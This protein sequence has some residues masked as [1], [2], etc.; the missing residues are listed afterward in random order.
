MKIPENRIN[1]IL[2]YE[3]FKKKFVPN[4]F[5]GYN[6]ATAEGRN[7]MSERIKMKSKQQVLF[8]FYFVRFIAFRYLTNTQITT[9]SSSVNHSYEYS[10]EEIVSHNK[11]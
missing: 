1:F 9:A 4:N 10:Y 5:V 8:C 11:R 3:D 2:K 6:M 7:I